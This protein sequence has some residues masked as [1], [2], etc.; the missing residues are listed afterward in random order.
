MKTTPTWPGPGIKPMPWWSLSLAVS[1]ATTFVRSATESV[2]LGF[3]QVFRCILHK[4][5]VYDKCQ[6]SVTNDAH[7]CIGYR[8]RFKTV[9]ISGPLQGTIWEQGGNQKAWWLGSVWRNSLIWGYC[10]NSSHI[11][12]MI[13]STFIESSVIHPNWTDL[14]R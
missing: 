6:M 12:L 5:F 14:L 10:T 4:M 13:I 1:K 7:I 3:I 8:E 11:Y 2:I 9:N